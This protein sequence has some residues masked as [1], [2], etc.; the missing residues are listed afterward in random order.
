[1]THALLAHQGCDLTVLR[2]GTDA[3]RQADLPLVASTQSR[4]SLERQVRLGAGLLVLTGVVFGLLLHPGWF[5]L[6][7]FVGT[8]LIFAGTTNYC[9][10]AN[11]LALLPWNRR[12]SGK[13]CSTALSCGCTIK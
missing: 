2:G 12:G 7:G 9:A 13:P 3:W 1:M 10:M 6:A 8:G 5:Y 11:L 4:W